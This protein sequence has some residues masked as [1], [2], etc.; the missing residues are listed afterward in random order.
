MKKITL[1]LMICIGVF[2]SWEIAQAQI[3]NDTLK[4]KFKRYIIKKYKDTSD[5]LYKAKVFLEGK[6]VY[7]LKAQRPGHIQFIGVNNKYTYD[8]TQDSIHN[9]IFQYYY[10]GE[11]QVN[12]WYILSLER[13]QFKVLDTIHSAYSSP[14]L[15]DFEKDE[16]YEI[17]VKDYTFAHWNASFL[18]SPY[19][20][21]ILEY[22]NGK[23]RVAPQR[24]TSS[25]DSISS[26]LAQEI[27]EG[28][29][30]FHEKSLETY[31]YT[32][33]V[34]GGKP[35][36]R[37][38]FIS[39]KLWGTM[40]HFIYT[41]QAQKALEFLNLA[42][43]EKIEGKEVFLQDF[44]KQLS[45]SPYWNDIEKMNAPNLQLIW[46]ALETKEEKK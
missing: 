35:E 7:Q 1:Y 34:L 21:V 40:L 14:W 23:Y 17:I 27:Q 19:E 2:F 38:G 4:I 5:S 22:R 31:P 24:M 11:D 13:F 46:S 20:K 8:I 36:Q 29:K 12:T 41:G 16:Q 37:W 10:G 15:S 6:E 33:N 28:M 45:Q 32:T 9:F 42:W 30:E 25:K 3:P 18:D 43:Y 44:Q 39:S 26:Q